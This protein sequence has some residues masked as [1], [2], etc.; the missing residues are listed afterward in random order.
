MAMNSAGLTSRGVCMSCCGAGLPF[1][2]AAAAAVAAAAAAF[3][4]IP[5]SPS[6][7]ACAFFAALVLTPRGAASFPGGLAVA[8]VAAF[9][10]VEAVA[11][12]VR[13][14]PAVLVS[15][16]V[17]PGFRRDSCVPVLISLSASLSAA[18]QRGSGVSICTFALVKQ[19]L[20]V[21]VLVY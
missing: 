3:L 14:L 17:L 2:A 21:C 11:E 7:T 10:A 13:G 6:S 15:E 20:S 18:T 8:A 4:G 12:A 5:G 1:L 16:S 19:G 9:A